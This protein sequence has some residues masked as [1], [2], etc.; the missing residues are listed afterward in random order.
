MG[1]I[2]KNQILQRWYICIFF[3]PPPLPHRKKS[4][5]FYSYTLCVYNRARIFCFLFACL[6]LQDCINSKHKRKRSICIVKPYYR[7]IEFSASCQSE[8]SQTNAKENHQQTNRKWHKTLF[9]SAVIYFHFA[10]FKES[11]VTM[12]NNKNVS[13]CV[14]M[15]DKHCR[16]ASYGMPNFFESN[17][18]SQNKEHSKDK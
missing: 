2:F 13:K 7:A 9:L 16:N 17:V 12:R 1:F 6:S 11:R 18:V 4:S 15:W 14:E 3:S 5:L 10:P 8:A